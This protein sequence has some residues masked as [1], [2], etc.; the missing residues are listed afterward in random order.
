MATYAANRRTTA[1]ARQLTQ[2][3]SSS[4]TLSSVTSF[5]RRRSTATGASGRAAQC[6]ACSRSLARGSSATSSS[7]S[8]SDPF[9]AYSTAARNDSE[10]RPCESDTYTLISIRD[11]LPLQQLQTLPMLIDLV[12]RPCP[13]WQRPPLPP[14]IITQRPL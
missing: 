10:P 5:R 12:A 7:T 13:L 8:R 9:R 4:S 14:P 11:K 3:T 6:T 2:W 1:T